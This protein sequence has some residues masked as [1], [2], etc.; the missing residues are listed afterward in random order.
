MS[1]FELPGLM[2]MYSPIRERL[3]LGSIV[4]LVAVKVEQ[5]L[6]TSVGNES[7]WSS[8]MTHSYERRR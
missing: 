7:S 1:I 4:D 2:V 5:E 8:W 3:K 6:P